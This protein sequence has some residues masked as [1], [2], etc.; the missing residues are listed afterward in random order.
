MRALKFCGT[1]LWQILMYGWLRTFIDRHRSQVTRAIVHPQEHVRLQVPRCW[2][3]RY[4]QL[5]KNY[6][7]Q[8]PAELISNIDEISLSDWE[9]RKE[10]KVLIPSGHIDSRL[11]DPVNWSI[12]HHTL[13]CCI[14]TAGDAY[15]PLL[16]TANRG[17]QMILNR[18]FAGTS[19]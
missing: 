13:I 11:H 9:E 18:A 19:I 7:P 8:I 10:K 3:D 5:I 15:S 14:S 12:R 16:I 17:A 2:L 4:I 1:E 6:I